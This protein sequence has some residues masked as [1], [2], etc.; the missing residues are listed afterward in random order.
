MPELIEISKNKNKD[1]TK[2]GIY[3]CGHNGCTNVFE[4]SIYDV[5]RKTTQSCSCL[6]SPYKSSNYVDNHQ[7]KLCECGC[8]QYT[9]K[10]KRSSKK[11]GY[12]RNEYKRYIK[13][14]FKHT[15]PFTKE[16]KDKISKALSG[17]KKSKEHRANQV[18]SQCGREIILSPFL[19]DITVRP[20]EDE[21][22]K[23]R[24]YCT[25]PL[26][27]KTITHAR[28]VYR[29]LVGEIPPDT[30]VHHKNG[31]PS[32]LKNDRPDNLIL[33][34]RTWNYVHFPYLERTFNIS[35]L[36]LTNLYL[37][38]SEKF[39]GDLLL[40]EIIGKLFERKGVA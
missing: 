19:E 3:K 36:D 4:T 25:D 13:N 35:T 16:T 11:Q 14:H 5:D 24:W 30:H 34:D 22:G 7:P 17:K 18:K 40:K 37:E 29:T 10:A 26:N 8:G 38:L 9:E 32:D 6:G 21:N 39:S 2:R 23:I 20:I 33:L 12:V 15:E 1:G 31:D 28:L 27:N